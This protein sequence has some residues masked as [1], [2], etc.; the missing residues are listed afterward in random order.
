[1]IAVA[2][3][4]GPRLSL[5][6]LLDP[7]VL[8]DPYPLYAQLRTQDPVHWDPYLHAWVVMRHDD[9]IT[10]LRGFSAARTPSAA[11]LTALGL[12]G[13]SPLA[14]VMVKQMLFLDPPAHTRIRSLASQAFTPHRV[15]QLRDHIRA[16]VARLLAP[17]V[18]TGRL[19][20]MADLAAPLPSIV[21][22]EML[23][24][25]ASD[26]RQLKLWSADFAEIL[27]NFQHNPDRAAR[28]LA[29]AEAL[30]AYFRERMAELRHGQGRPGLVAS[31]LSAEVNGDRLSE[32]EVVANAIIT[33]VGGQET[34]TNLIG[35][36]LLA[37]LRHPAELARLRA[38]PALVPSAVEELLRFESP[39]QHTAR[40][41]PADCALRGHTVL[42]GQA[43]V[44]VLGAANRDP[45]VFLQPDHLDLGRQ[46]N[47]HLAFGFGAH[48][49]FGAALARIEAQEAFSAILASFPRLSLEPG[50]GPLAWRP[51]LALRGLE[52]L[53]LIAA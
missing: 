44:V 1:M 51:N 38:C 25:P 11:Q 30:T 34:T 2:E 21:T 41:A 20:L 3:N 7:A 13:L 28:T 16:I 6:R 24:V 18:A 10:V 45:A 19:E 5:T 53:P 17:A 29:A 27:G 43:V 50:A 33:M 36:G 9:A 32:E 46:P 14:A 23:G 40:L 35:N 37:L 49:C 22:A 48:F 12:G 39:T 42:H 52:A 47:H 31:L 4:A 8:A 26:H 15:A